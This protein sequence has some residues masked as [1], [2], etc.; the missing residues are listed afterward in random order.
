VK[1][2][3]Q[4]TPE[5]QAKLDSKQEYVTKMEEIGSYYGM[6]KKNRGDSVKEETKVEAVPKQEESKVDNSELLRFIAQLVVISNARGP[7]LNEHFSRKE[8]DVLFSLLTDK[9]YQLAGPRADQLAQNL[10]LFVQGSSEEFKQGF[11][12]E[13]LKKKL[14]EKFADEQFQKLNL[15]KLAKKHEEKKEE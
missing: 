4:I 9:R 6:Y 7:E 10:A 5:Q 11:T 14:A 13:Q 2:G 15:S 8:Q 12:Y 1:E 3:K